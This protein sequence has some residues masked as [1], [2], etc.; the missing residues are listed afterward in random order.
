[1]RPITLDSSAPQLAPATEIRDESQSTLVAIQP[2]GTRPA[3]YLVHNICGGIECYDVL[4]KAL[5]P[6]QPIYAF[7]HASY[8]SEHGLGVQELASIY[9][10]D[11]L[12]FDPT[13]HH[14]LGGYS[15]GGLV[16]F[17][18]AQ[19]L[20][21]IGQRPAM[22][23]MLDTWL[24]SYRTTLSLGEQAQIFSQNARALGLKYIWGKILNKRH[25]WQR[26]AKNEFLRIAG[27]A[28]KR[29]GCNPP[30]L[31]REARVERVNFESLQT[32]RPAH[33]AGYVLHMFCKDRQETLSKRG[34]PYLG[35][36]ILKD[37]QFE[38]YPIPFDHSSLL[39]E[40]STFLI[41]QH[42][43]NILPPSV[44]MAA[45]GSKFASK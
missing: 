15:F 22:V 45:A 13:G 39:K 26:L 37:A 14:L 2:G 16:A 10:R 18:M 27:W 34:D 33:Y 1:M 23:V 17:E 8:E 30:R 6:D 41:A 25:Y 31:V 32:Y 9:I 36:G 19:Q 3:L 29:I 28:C 44:S 38:M 5:G 11:L 20:E 12:A 40:P 35:W 21:A 24:P 42:L 7:R 4:A 43:Q